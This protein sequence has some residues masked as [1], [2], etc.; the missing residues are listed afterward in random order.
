MSTQV[1][2]DQFKWHGNKLIHEPTG[3]RFTIG[4]Q[5]VNYGRAGSVLPNGDDFEK[6]DVL[7]VAHQLI[8]EGKSSEH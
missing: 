6:E 2:R 3:A 4:S 5:I 8:L 1:N 7:A